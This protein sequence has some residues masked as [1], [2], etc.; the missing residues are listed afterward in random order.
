MDNM[1][2]K[3]KFFGIWFSKIVAESTDYVLKKLI[4]LGKNEKIKITM[5]Y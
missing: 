3:E 1:R 5:G 2:F 4:Y